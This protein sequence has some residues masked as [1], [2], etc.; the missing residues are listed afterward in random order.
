MKLFVISFLISAV[1]AQF[2]GNQLGTDVSINSTCTNSK[3]V[4]TCSING[5][6]C[7][8]VSKNKTASTASICIPSEFNNQTFTISSVTYNFSC[9]YAPTAINATSINNTGPP[10]V[11]F[12]CLDPTTCCAARTWMFKNAT[13]SNNVSYTC[14]DPSTQGVVLWGSYSGATNLTG[15]V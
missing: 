13:G 1:S 3:S 9:N 14:V 7:G 2:L 10:C 8:N 15:D 4:E 5:F 6:C 12:T 11:N